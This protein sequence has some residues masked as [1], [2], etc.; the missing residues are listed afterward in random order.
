MGK[1]AEAVEQAKRT[2]ELLDSKRPYRNNYS[3]GMHTGACA[4]PQS[5]A[6]AAFKHLIYGEA[7]QAQVVHPEGH[8]MMRLHWTSAGIGIWAP[9]HAFERPTKVIT[10]VER[11]EKEAARAKRAAGNPKLQR[12]K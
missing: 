8:D 4:S 12:V 1:V 5:A 6:V 2:A 11:A 9:P 7:S 10:P 3:G